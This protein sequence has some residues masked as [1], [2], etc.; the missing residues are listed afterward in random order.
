MPDGRVPWRGSGRCSRGKI[1]A[2]TYPHAPVTYAADW[3]EHVLVHTGQRELVSPA[4]LPLSDNLYGWSKAAYE[5]LG[6]VYSEVVY[7]TD[8]RRLLTGARAR[9]RGGRLG[10]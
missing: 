6:F 4:D 7:A 9:A 8:V 3:Y 1:C 10:G 2:A 5:L